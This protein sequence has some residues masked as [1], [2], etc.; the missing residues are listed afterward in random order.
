MKGIISM[1]IALLAA[2][3][4]SAFIACG[5]ELPTPVQLAAEPAMP[6]TTGTATSFPAPGLNNG[7]CV[8]EE[9]QDSYDISS[10][11]TAP[12]HNWVYDIRVSGED[13]HMRVS[14]MEE[15]GTI[16]EFLGVNGVTYGRT[17]GVGWE[18]LEQHF[19]L[20]SFIKIHPIDGSSALCP[21]INS[22]V[23]IGEDIVEESLTNRY[24]IIEQSAGNLGPVANVDGSLTGPLVSRTWDIWVQP[25]GRLVQTK[26]VADYAAT[27]NYAAFQAEVT[28]IISGIGE[29]NTITAPTLPTPT[30][31][32]TATP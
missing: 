6:L 4:I 7:E 15:G 16:T 22:A 19:S 12:T 20:R 17:E 26:L 2:A 32:P 30:P 28:T 29:P 25:D 24:R 9:H 23:E 11:S 27:A 13:Y 8:P 21:E 1:L 18:R 3:S 31:T 14:Q 5:G 10:V